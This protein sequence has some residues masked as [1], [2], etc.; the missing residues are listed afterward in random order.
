MAHRRKRKAHRRSPRRSKSLGFFIPGIPN[1]FIW[2]GMGLAGGLWYLTKGSGV[3]AAGSPADLAAAEQIF[4]QIR[5]TSGLVDNE[6]EAL[7][8]QLVTTGK[9]PT[10][11]VAAAMVRQLQMTKDQ[12]QPMGPIGPVQSMAVTAVTPY[13]PTV[14]VSSTMTKAQKAVAA[15][16]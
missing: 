4:A 9:A 5:A 15:G 14:Y 1:L 8:H 2:A 6:A 3:P 12:E 16:F 11:A 13:T 7:A 10:L